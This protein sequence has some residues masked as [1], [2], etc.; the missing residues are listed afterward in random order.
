MLEVRESSVP[1]AGLGVFVAS[2]S[3][4]IAKDTLVT[5]YGSAEAVEDS[6]K[7][8]AAARYNIAVPGKVGWVRMAYPWDEPLPSRVDDGLLGHKVGHLI[9]DAAALP[10]T[11]LGLKLMYTNVMVYANASG[12]G[13]NVV[14]GKD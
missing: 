7:G 6:T 4:P 13:M 9:N 12:E 3:A 14:M 10:N 1:G 11:G 5:Y 8:S 2:D